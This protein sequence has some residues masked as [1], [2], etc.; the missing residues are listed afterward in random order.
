MSCLFFRR[1]EDLQFQIEE[2]V[3]SKD[4]LE[5]RGALIPDPCIKPYCSQ[6]ELQLKVGK[7]ASGTVVFLL[8]CCI[9]SGQLGSHPVVSVNLITVLVFWVWEYVCH[10]WAAWGSSSC[11]NLVTTLALKGCGSLLKELL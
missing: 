9:I 5:V 7:I 11:M 4:D 2:E 6:Q 1:I 10:Q 8:A 3:I